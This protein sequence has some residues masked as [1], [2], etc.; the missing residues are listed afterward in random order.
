MQKRTITAVCEYCGKEFI[1]IDPSNWN[2]HSPQRFCSRICAGKGAA[3]ERGLHVRKPITFTCEHCGKPFTRKARADREY[4]Y[5][6][7]EC[8]IKHNRGENHH[9][10]QGGYDRYYGPNWTE[11][12]L[13]A[14]ERDSYA[15]QDCGISDDWMDVHH[16]TPRSEFDTSEWKAM[17]DI[18]NLVTLCH[19][20][21]ARRH[22]DVERL[23]SA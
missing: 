15:C 17:N 16:I 19:S 14:L 9:N 18:S 7:R 21:H 12:R 2:T 6:S 11:Q 20:C 3:K 23:N 4:R 5:C 22:A 8:Y 13:K 10:W 1:Q